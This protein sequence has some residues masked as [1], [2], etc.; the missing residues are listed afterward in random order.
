MDPSR[1]DYPPTKV[2]AVTE[3]LHGEKLPDPYR[4]LEDGRAADV[5]EWTERQNAFTRK[6]LDQFPGRDKLRAR[7]DQLL[8]I[9]TLSAP[10]PTKGRYFHTRREGKQNQPVLFVRDGVNGTDRVVL[11]VNALS[12]EGT[13]AL[14]WYFPSQ[15]GK[16]LAYGLSVGGSEMSTLRIRDV[17]IGN[18]LPDVIDRCRACSLAWLPTSDGFYYTRYPKTGEVAAGEETYHRRTFFHRLGDDP[19]KDVLIFGKDRP[20][21]DWPNLSLSPDGKWLAITQQQG[22]AKSEVYVA[23]ATGRTN[24]EFKPLAEGIAAIFQPEVTNEHIFLRTNHDA[25]RYK[26]YR[27]A[28]TKLL[29]EDWL[30]VIPQSDDILEQFTI[31]EKTIAAIFMQRASSRLRM[32]DLDG[33]NK[34]DVSLPALGTVTSVHSEPDG[35]ELFF[36]YHSFTI[37]AQAFRIE[38]PSGAM[39][40]WAEIKA[41]I[42]FNAYTVQQVE[43]QSKDGT[44]ISMFLAAK[45]GTPRDGN[46]PTILYGYGGF[47]ISLTPSFSPARFAFLE[48]GG[49]LAVANLRGGGEFG[50]SWHQAGML[51]NKQNTFDDF[52]AAAEWLVRE[53]VTSPKRLAIQG[54]SNGGLLVGAAL[55]QRPD[56][57]QAVVCAVPLLDMLR[58]HRFQIARL[59][60]PEYG[61]AESSEQFHWL[62]QYSP[63][64]HVKDGVQY[65]AVLITTAESDTRVDPLHARKMAALLQKATSS[66]RP[67]LVRIE[68]AAGHG[69]GKPRSKQLDELTD[70]YSFIFAQLGMKP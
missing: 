24:L 4:W 9:G 39:K 52:I 63:Y 21:E 30:E 68:T 17:D 44:P 55:T 8:E 56:L 15:D 12:A 10:H 65:P 13:T 14:D 37:P 11:D 2:E 60:I 47:N 33:E 46:N 28:P 45:K 32:F 35:K 70:V 20:K 49:V 25:P 22:W 16:L 51:A 6:W 40:L 43:Y 7:L 29:R 19:T 62:R 42:D 26:L 50:E 58:Y 41:N 34:R 67:I 66:D 38:L 54:G 36:G 3:D 53:R 69:A 5:R 59:W 48:R 1:P 64:H 57:F 23:D 31:A 27:I 18:D 61:S